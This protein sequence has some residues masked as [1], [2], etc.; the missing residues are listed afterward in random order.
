MLPM[1]GEIFMNLHQNSSN[2]ET[3]IEEE[4]Q[5]P[6]KVFSNWY[7]FAIQYEIND[8]EAMN[9]ATVSSN[10]QPSS[11]M[12]L[13][14]A[15]DETGFIF[16]TNTE[17]KKSKEIKANDLVALNFHWKSLRRQVRIE[18]KA[19][20]ISNEEANK[21]FKNRPKEL[22]ISA[23]ASKQSDILPNRKILD[24]RVY[25]YDDIFKNTPVERPEFWSGYKIIPH[26]FEYWWDVKFRLHYRIVYQQ[27]NNDWIKYM[28]FP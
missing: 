8:P 6:F 26:Y 7:K 13:L 15:Y 5:D 25:D 4:N 1:I 19:Q 11:R 16:N 20:L 9:V 24:K 23:W 14:K 28:L 27:K 21:Y 12:I 3:L 2:K 10:M 17:S 18:G 22:Q